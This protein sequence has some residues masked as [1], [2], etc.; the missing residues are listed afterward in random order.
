MDTLNIIGRL[1]AIEK[2]LTEQKTVLTAQEAACYMAISQST[3]YKLTSAGIVPFSKPNGKLIY[4]S[5]DSLDQWLLSNSSKSGEE[6]DIQVAT[7]ISK[8][9]SGGHKK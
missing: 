9:Q 2:L 4:F 3:L 1:R 7:Y 5:K 6:K 8:V